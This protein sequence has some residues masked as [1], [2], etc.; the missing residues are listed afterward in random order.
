VVTERSLGAAPTE[1][2]SRIAAALSILGGRAY[3]GAPWFQELL[4][5]RDGA[6]PMEGNFV[7]SP[8]VPYGTRS[9]TVLELGPDRVRLWERE[10]A[11]DRPWVDHS[12]AAMALL[13]RTGL[14][15]RGSG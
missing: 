7:T 15:P 14:N 3:P 13:G 4:S 1:R 2:P 9:S 12:A 8:G 11:V 10:G 6:A 5:R